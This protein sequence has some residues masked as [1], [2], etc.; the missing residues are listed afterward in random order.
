MPKVPLASRSRREAQIIALHLIF[1]A[2]N[3]T[4]RS[5]NLRYV[6]QTPEW[7][8][9]HWDWGAISEPLAAI[10]FRRGQLVMAMASLGFEVRQ[11]AVLQVLVQDVTK[12][13][14][15]EG[16]HLNLDQVRS[17]IAKRLGMDF[18]GLPT[19]DRY[20]EGVVDMMLDATQ[21][22]QAPLDDERIFGWHAA[23][24]PTGRSGMS[25]I[26]VGEYRK[27]E[28]QIV[29]GPM[30]KEK[31]HFEAPS[32]DRVPLEMAR[33]LDWFETYKIDPV[34]R[35]AIAHIWFETIHPLDDGNGRIGRAIMDKAL[36]QADHTN[37]RFYSMTA[38]IH[39]D[40]LSYY[41][42]LEKSQHGGL[43]ITE[44]LFWF[45][46]KLDLALASAESVLSLVRRKAHFWDHFR[47]GL[48]ERQAK[49][50][51]LLFAG[52]DGKLRTGKYAKIA[53]CSDA[54]AQRDLSDLVAK[55]AL[56]VDPAT[57]G[58]GTAYILAPGF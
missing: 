17:S 44:W 48:N 51:N 58:R 35:A 34:V 42:I 33:F 5:V 8:N 20:V 13:S 53:K 14:E 55:G 32:P 36:A 25:K 12:S 26:T 24:F 56:I 31:V 10:H 37:Q 27:G 3:G 16:E 49:I 45:F 40:K 47:E 6:H 30:G 28:M 19:P 57:T 15:I 46:T 2:Q 29:S 52:F 21:R 22:F 41:A 4:I 39:A 54:T 23:L 50:V 11:E 1:E 9:Y 7:P 38:Q 43:D 18:A